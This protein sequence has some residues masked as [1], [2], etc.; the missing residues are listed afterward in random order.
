MFFFSF[1]FIIK[2]VGGVDMNVINKD[3]FSFINQSVSCFHAIEEIK[4]R[5][6]KEGFIELKEKDAWSLEK[7][8]KYYTIRSGSSVV[9]FMIPKE[10]KDYHF[11]ITSSHSDSPAF[12]VKEN[13]DVKGNGYLQL[14]VEGYGGMLCS[15]WLDRPLSLCGR[16]LV[17]EDNKI[18]SKLVKAENSLLMIP[19]VAIHMNRE[20]NS[21]QS[22]NVQVDMLPLLS[23]NTDLQYK[24][25]LA[26]YTN[27]NV[28]DIVSSD[29]VLYNQQTPVEWGAE[30]EFIA[31]PRLDDLQCAYTSLQAFIQGKN[32][33][34]NVYACFD[35]EEVG[36]QTK[37]GAAS[38]FLDDVLV[39]INESLS[40]SQEQYRQ[41]IAKSF[42]I[43]CDNAHAMH[44]NH[45]EKAD[46]Q[47]ACYLNGGIVIKH[48]ANQKYTSDAISS[49]IFA[50]ICAKANAKVQHFNNRSDMVG[51]STLGN[52]SATQVSLHTV[53]V[54]LAQLAMHSSYESAG[55]KDSEEMIKAL[56]YFYTHMVMIH[57]FDEIEIL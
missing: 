32:E 34:I 14:N 23:L 41:A 30:K 9:A 31:A 19:N 18:V 48:S 6:L 43:S 36:S 29:I 24:Q 47:N 33:A 8:K 35:N 17:K 20:A 11:Q 45:P 42:M 21:G 3:L 13:A 2:N 46:K 10:I 28:K 12:K 51:G 50:Q 26:N 7:G 53:D 5:L 1:W 16:V 4:Q 37:Q 15:S 25:L 52:I 38:T 39:R 54:G 40:Y 57:H 27:V 44:P 55:A 22:Y 56:T 49:A